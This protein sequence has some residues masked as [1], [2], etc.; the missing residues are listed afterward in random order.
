[1]LKNSGMTKDP[2]NM[3]NRGNYKSHDQRE[4]SNRPK[5]M[6]IQERIEKRKKRGRPRRLTKGNKCGNNWFTTT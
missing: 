4:K 3:I 6:P 5:K 2:V 1:M